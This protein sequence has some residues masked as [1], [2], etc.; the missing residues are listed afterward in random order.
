M[1]VNITHVS[2]SSLGHSIILKNVKISWKQNAW[3]ILNYNDSFK[4]LLK[5]DAFFPPTQSFLKLQ[6]IKES[7]ELLCWKWEYPGS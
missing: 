7:V 2:K 5:F 3:E 4:I 1:S 6:E